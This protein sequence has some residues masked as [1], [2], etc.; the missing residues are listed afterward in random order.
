MLRRE[1]PGE[2]LGEFLRG[3]GVP[4]EI[5]NV[6]QQYGE[7]V[8]LD[9]PHLVIERGGIAAL[10][11]PNGAGKTTLLRLLAGLD[12]PSRGE[13]FLNG[14]MLRPGPSQAEARRKVTLVHQHPYLFRSTVHA[15]VAYG[16]KRRGVRGTALHDRVIAA[17]EAVRLED[18]ARRG[19]HMLS[20]GEAQRVGIARALAIQPEVILL[21]EPTAHADQQSVGIVQRV[22]LAA[23]CNGATV[24]L[25]SHDYDLMA[26]LPHQRIDMAYG[27]IE[28]VEQHGVEG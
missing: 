17:L 1:L 19:A 28:K 11:G 18:F 4:Y 22:I 10:L 16:L 20:A 14:V 15:N 8:V 26:G 3:L 21:D 23:T 2:F 9:I 13:I 7:T 25:A 5:H 12:A 24:I 6:Q 27:R